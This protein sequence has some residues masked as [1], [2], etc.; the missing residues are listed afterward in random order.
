MMPK[1]FQVLSHASP[2]FYSVHIDYNVLFGGGNTSH[3]LIGLALIAGVALVINSVIHG[4]KSGQAK[5]SEQGMAMM[6]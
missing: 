1:F 2:M 5:T 3:Y 6:I 4:L